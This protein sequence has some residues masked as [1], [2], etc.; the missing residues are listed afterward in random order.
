MGN[1]NSELLFTGERLM[2]EIN[3]YWSIEHLHRYALALN[4]VRDKKIIDIASGEGYG[5]NILADSAAFVTGIDIS[6]V[7]IKH[8]KNKYKKHNLSYVHGS[9]TSIPMNDHS[10]DIVISFE[11]IEHLSEHDQMITEIKRVLKPHGVLIISS[12]DKKY[13]SDIPG[14]CNPFHVKELYAKE[15]NELIEKYFTNVEIL[16]Q[17][18]IFGSII[19]GVN[20]N[21]SSLTE[22]HGNYSGISSN[23]AISSPLYNICVA[24]DNQT[25][26][27]PLIN[28]SIFANADMFE[29]YTKFKVENERLQ[30][31][32]YNLRSQLGGPVQKVIR[33]IQLPW[34]LLRKIIK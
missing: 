2:T 4:F 14:Y 20:R 17:K 31:E 24:S 11:T 13:Y 25:S 22:F 19:T 33:F 34:K 16:N 6:E 26:L 5:S 12:P 7:A 1:T 21:G 29:L 3:E 15:F 9:A 27:K 10:I 28:E 32:N 18:S 8:S 30:K 23:K